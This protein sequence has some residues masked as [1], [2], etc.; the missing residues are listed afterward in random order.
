M[1]WYNG[2]MTTVGFEYRNKRKETPFETFLRYTDEKEKSAIKLAAIL[3]ENVHEGSHILDIGTGNGEYLQLALSKFNLPENI[4]LTLVEPSDDLVVQLEGRFARQLPDVN[5]KVVHSDL[6]NFDS[7]KQYDV[8]LMSH[9]FYHIPRSTWTAQL[10]KALTLLKSDG[11]LI[12]V[13]REKDDA[14]DFKMSFKP[15]LFG[16]SFKA[17]TID[18]VLAA[19]PKDPATEIRKHLAES[20][21]KIPFKE[22]HEDAVSI[23]EFYLNKRWEEMPES[24]QQRVLEFIEDKYGVFKQRDCI[25]VI[26]KL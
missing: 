21:L 14:Y 8:I 20:E 18:D 12:T 22:S 19:L 10:A 25:A 26:K 23:I 1:N 7:D 16:E 4:T 11:L 17:L 5:L 3:K 15:F 9:L 2:F 13:L 6:Q 24:I